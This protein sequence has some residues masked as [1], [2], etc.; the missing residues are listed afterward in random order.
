MW[1]ESCKKQKAIILADFLRVIFTFLVSSLGFLPPPTP[2]TLITNHN[3]LGLI[4][5]YENF[6]PKQP[7]RESEFISKQSSGDPKQTL[8]WRGAPRGMAAGNEIVF[9]AGAWLFAPPGFSEV[10]EERA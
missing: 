2:F 8:I 3:Q 5:F 4:E 6:H 10:A 9:A 7:V 1:T